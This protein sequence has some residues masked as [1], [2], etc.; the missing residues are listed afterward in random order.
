MKILVFDDDKDIIDLMQ[1]TLETDGHQIICAL[2]GKECVARVKEDREIELIIA[3]IRVPVMDGF[4]TIQVLRD[5]RL[6]P[7][8]PIIVMAGFVGPEEVAK[9]ASLGISQVLEK[10]VS[11]EDLRSAIQTAVKT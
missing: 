3:D 4:D 9:S 1:D 2:E 11:L 7:P 8:V 5:L 10:P 6:D